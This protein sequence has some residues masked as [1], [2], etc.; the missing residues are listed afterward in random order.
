MKKFI[1]ISAM[2]VLLSFSARSQ[3]VI[4]MEH[5]YEDA[6]TYLSYHRVLQSDTPQG[7]LFSLWG[8]HKYN[9]SGD[10]Y[11]AEYF[12]ANAREMFGFLTTVSELTAKYRNEENILIQTHGVKVKLNTLWNTVICVYDGEDKVFGYFRIKVWNRMLN[13]FTAFCDINGISYKD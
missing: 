9:D 7:H 3:T 6:I 5:I 8:M 12:K 4:K 2:A 10:Y 11:D 1:L 13:D